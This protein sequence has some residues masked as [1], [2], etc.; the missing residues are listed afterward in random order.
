MKAPR[1]ESPV[2]CGVGRWRAAAVWEAADR[3]RDCQVVG[4]RSIE[5]CCGTGRWWLLLWGAGG[6]GVEVVS[7]EFSPCMATK[8]GLMDS[9]QRSQGGRRCHSNGHAQTIP[10]EDHCLATC[11]IGHPRQSILHDSFRSP[12]TQS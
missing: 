7:W 4:S 12:V 8:L 5:G 2:G 1:D 9:C 10:S 11:D 3:F 6:C